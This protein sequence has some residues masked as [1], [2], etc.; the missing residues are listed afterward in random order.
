MEKTS[1][2]V[3]LWW[4]Q[5]RIPEKNG[6]ASHRL[7]ENIWKNISDKD[8]YPEYTKY[9]VIRR[10]NN[11]IKKKK[12]KRVKDLTISSLTKKRYKEGK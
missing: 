11:S 8:N 5:K 3:Y 10:Q 6:K 2:K 7:G 1:T 4:F 12:K 9:S